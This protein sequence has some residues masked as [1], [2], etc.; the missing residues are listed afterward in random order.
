M[1]TVLFNSF[2]VPAELLL[3]SQTLPEMPNP[4]GQWLPV[5]SVYNNLMARWK[6]DKPPVN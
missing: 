1:A 3:F 5:L 2:K 4:V 6:I